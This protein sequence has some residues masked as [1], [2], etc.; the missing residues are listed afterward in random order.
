MIVKTTPLEPMDILKKGE[1][2]ANN[3]LY[4]LEPQISLERFKAAQK[5]ELEIT[6][7]MTFKKHYKHLEGLYDSLNNMKLVDAS[8]QLR[9]LMES[10]KRLD[11]M[12]D[13][14]PIMKYCALILNTKDE[15]RRWIDEK[16]MNVKIKDWEMEGIP[17][18]SF[19]A[20][21]LHSVAGYLEIY[22]EIS[23]SILENQEVIKPSLEKN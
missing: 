10:M 17:I 2:T 7:S 6:F 3:R 15:D 23:Q 1:F 12:N 11:D 14:H 9:D 22:K 20:V 16:E 19:F 4:F 13:I 21:V 5:L 18:S 8:V